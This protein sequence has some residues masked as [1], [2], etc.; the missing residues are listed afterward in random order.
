M[1]TISKKSTEVYAVIPL[2]GKSSRMG[3]FKP[4]LPFRKEVSIRLLINSLLSGGVDKIIAVIG[5]KRELIEEA[6]E[7]YGDKIELIYNPEYK[8][9]DMLYS[10]KLGVKRAPKDSTI[11][12]TPGDMPLI[13]GKTIAYLIK[14]ANKNPNKILIPMYNKNSGHPVLIAPEYRDALIAY[15]EEMGL[16]GFLSRWED[17]ILRL[18]IDD[19]AVLMDLDTQDDYKKAQDMEERE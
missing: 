12:I 7:D 5:Y 17:S 9:S 11:M 18:D 13:K 2:A 10:I 8:S 19:E 6:I 3:S 1:K 4:L 15:S 16:R 14:E